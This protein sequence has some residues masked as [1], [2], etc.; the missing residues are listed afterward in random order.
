MINIQIRTETTIYTT[1]DTSV[2]TSTETGA[3]MSVGR[4]SRKAV[5][6]KSDWQATARL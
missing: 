3:E 4:F 1:I 2:D 6:P 5:R